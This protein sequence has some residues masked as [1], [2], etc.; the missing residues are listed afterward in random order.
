MSL[1]FISPYLITTLP[2]L[3]TEKVVSAVPAGFS[4]L[5]RVW[6]DWQKGKKKGTNE[7]MND[8]NVRQLQVCIIT[9]NKN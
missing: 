8:L 4:D 1:P 6:Q 2:S 5:I 9:D 3:S 7:P